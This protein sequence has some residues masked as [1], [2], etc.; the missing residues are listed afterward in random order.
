MVA[1]GPIVG[2]AEELAQA[3]LGDDRL[4]ASFMGVSGYDD[5]VPDL[6]AAAR[7]A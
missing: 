3:R 4:L 6:S 5:A 1:A 7:Q 2:L